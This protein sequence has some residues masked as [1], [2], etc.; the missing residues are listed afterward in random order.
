MPRPFREEVLGKKSCSR[1]FTDGAGLFS[2][3]NMPKESGYSPGT[4]L[5]CCKGAMEGRDPEG[6]SQRCHS[7]VTCLFIH[8]ATFAHRPLCQP[9][10]E[11]EGAHV[12]PP[13][14]HGLG[15]AGTETDH[16]SRGRRLPWGWYRDTEEPGVW[17]IREGFL[18][19]V[20]S[21]LRGTG[22]VELSW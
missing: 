3:M 1:S 21:E 13:R 5:R 10:G 14:S 12:A 19:E 20:I 15:E 7:L 2:F 22:R 18:E 11:V 16:D 9:G 17:C 4:N 8:S 6:G